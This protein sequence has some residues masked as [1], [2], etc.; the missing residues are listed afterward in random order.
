MTHQN[1]KKSLEVN[2]WPG[3]SDLLIAMVLMLILYL[4][5]QEITFRLSEAYKLE[6]MRIRQGN[7]KEDLF[8]ALGPDSVIIADISEETTIQK[9]SFRSAFLFDEG[10]TEFKD[11]RSADLIRRIGE[12]IKVY[13]ERNY[14]NTVVVE[15]H[16]NSRAFN[17]SKFNNWP[18]SAL[19]AVTVMRILDGLN[20]R[21]KTADGRERPSRILSIAGFAY[22]D[23]VQDSLRYVIDDKAIQELRREGIG[24]SIVKAL[25]PIKGRQFASR[26]GSSGRAEKSF[27]EV[28]QIH[29][30][31]ENYRRYASRIKRAARGNFGREDFEESKRIQFTLEYNL[32]AVFEER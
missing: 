22:H 16:T 6:Q 21:S 3:F 18:L 26:L 28:L 1:R 20:I 4:F 2:I 24:Q 25:E 29:L 9:I 17:R 14:F 23:Y 15:G 11:I 8:K 27:E 12:V 7:F 5:L 13:V 19:R 10:K 32:E 30:T 31:A